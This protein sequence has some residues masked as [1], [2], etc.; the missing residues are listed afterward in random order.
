VFLGKA[1][2]IFNSYIF[3]HIRQTQRSIEPLQSRIPD[4]V[5]GY[6]ATLLI[7]RTHKNG[8]KN[9][10]TETEQTK[11]LNGNFKSI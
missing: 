6:C 3:K 2:V 4:D 8:S 1:N 5:V 7:E 9:R 11:R 10:S